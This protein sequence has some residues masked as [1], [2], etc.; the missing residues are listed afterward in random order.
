[1][2]SASCAAFSCDRMSALTALHSDSDRASTPSSGTV[3]AGFGISP[4]KETHSV[5]RFKNKHGKKKKRDSS[6][7]ADK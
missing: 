5:R 1:M 2:A 4:W 6:V 7:R 3:F